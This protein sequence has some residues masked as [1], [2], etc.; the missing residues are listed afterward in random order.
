MSVEHSEVVGVGGPAPQVCYHP[1]A[2]ALGG[3]TVP[4]LRM[5]DY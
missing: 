4:R 5:L 3:V 1:L 2:V